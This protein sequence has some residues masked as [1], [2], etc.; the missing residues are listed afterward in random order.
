[1]GVKGVVVDVENYTPLKGAT[2]T[3]ANSP[4]GT[5]TNEK[6]EFFIPL[7]SDKASE[8]LIRASIMGYDAQEVKFTLGNTDTEFVSFALKNKDAVIE[9]VVVTRRREKASELALLE[10]RRKSNLMVESIGSQE[11]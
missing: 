10:E 5:T 4:L 11:L 1:Y 8:Y 2:I 7:P 9:E 6:G 3:I